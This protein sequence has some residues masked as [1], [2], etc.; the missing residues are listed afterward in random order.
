MNNQKRQTDICFI[1][2][3]GN[4]ESGQI[5]HNYLTLMGYLEANGLKTEIIDFAPQAR[6]FYKNTSFSF[7]KGN[8]L[9]DDLFFSETVEKLQEIKP[10]YVGIS[11]YT[12]DYFLVKDFLKVLKEKVDAKIIMGNVHPS[13]FPEDL[14]YFG[15]PADYAVIG[16]GEDALLE[17]LQK[18]EGHI[19]EIDGLCFMDGEKFYRTGPRELFD[20][21]K[22]PPLPFERLDM[23]YYIKPKMS[24]IRNL[25]LVGAGIFSG[26]GCPYRCTFCSADS[27]YKAQGVVK[28]VRMQSLDKVFQNIDTLVT[29]YKVDAIYI[30]DETFSLSKDR[31]FDF[32]QRIK[33]YNIIWGAETRVNLINEEMLSAMKEAGCVQLDFGVE[34]GSPEMLEL[35]DKHITVPEIIKAFEMCDKY[36]I[37]TFA[38][39]LIN[40][41]GE[42]EKHI[43][44]TEELLKKIRPTVINV[45]K[46][47]P[48]PATSIF[49]NN[50]GMNHVEYIDTLKKFLAGDNT[51]FIMH[52]HNLKL[53]KIDRRFRSYQTENWKSNFKIEFG[54]FLRSRNR[55]IYCN[56]FLRL[57]IVNS[58]VWMRKKL[59]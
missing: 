8:K 36:G 27:I 30:M 47:K 49:D 9:D 58:I 43:Q 29:K 55:M 33:K 40:L 34:S 38:N 31:V 42:T 20:L 37:R 23:K 41:P 15:S 22:L 13:L 10:K 53:S 4:W 35:T 17:L 16:E 26:R 1:T 18:G 28:R 7:F 14:I 39:I 50:I 2:L 56:K 44:E 21:E 46:L 54:I 57:I 59:K 52:K 48:Y 25:V 19:K 32:C 51:V 11:M 24:L 45:S 3:P 5:P 12:T 6:R